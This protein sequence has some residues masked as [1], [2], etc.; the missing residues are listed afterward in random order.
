MSVTML[1]ERMT[2][3]T[4]TIFAEITQLAVDTGAINLGQG[5]PP[6]TDGPASLLSD[7]CTNIMGG[8]NQYPPGPGVPPTLRTAVASHQE[9]FYGL[10]VDPPPTCSSP[11]V[12]PRRSRRRS[13]R[14]ARRAT[15]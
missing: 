2:P 6:D 4:S 7:T 8:L 10:D 11:W 3:F 12:R 5:F 14:C 1:V 9:R 15:R 13:C